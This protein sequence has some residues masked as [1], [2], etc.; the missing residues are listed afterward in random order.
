MTGPHD[1]EVEVVSN[2]AGIYLVRIT[3]ET[4][5]YSLTNVLVFLMGC[6]L[7]RQGLTELMR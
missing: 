1:V 3:P 2:A 6:E 5:F 7:T 4:L